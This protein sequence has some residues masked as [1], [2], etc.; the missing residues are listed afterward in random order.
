MTACSISHFFTEMIAIFYT[1]NE[2]IEI[3]WF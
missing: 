2:I 1:I 3:K